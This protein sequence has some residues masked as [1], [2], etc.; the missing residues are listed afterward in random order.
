MKDYL[1]N[2]F[3]AF[4]RFCNAILAGN[5]KETISTRLAR[6]RNKGNDLGELGCKVLDTID[7]DH[8]DEAIKTDEA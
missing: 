4:D 3:V 8:C 7:N 1:W 2:I 5:P 6:L